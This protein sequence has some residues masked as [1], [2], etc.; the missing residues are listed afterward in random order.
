MD[1]ERYLIILKLINFDGSIKE[2]K[3]LLKPLAW[4]YEESCP[5]LNYRHICKV[6]QRYLNDELTKHDIEEWANLVE[7]RE[8]IT[9]E[10]SKKSLL[11]DVIHELANPKLT[12]NLSIERGKEIIDLLNLIEP[13]SGSHKN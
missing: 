1:D 13:E 10:L 9:F 4:D 7:G 8:D 11:Q 2:L 12:T 6:I 3:S 5:E